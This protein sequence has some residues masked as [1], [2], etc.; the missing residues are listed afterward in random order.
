MRLSDEWFTVL[1]S[2]DEGRIVY[3]NG[4]LS[5]EEFRKSRKLS[6]RIELR[7]PY[8][9]GS[10]GM[11]TEETAE[12]ILQIEERIRPK[13]EKDKLAILT[14]N[15]IGGGV[16][17]WVFYCRTERVFEERLNEALADLPLLPLEIDVD[18]DADWEEYLDML[19]MN[20]GG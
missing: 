5:L 1:S 16:K 11:P 19:S 18:L 2:D 9:M 15:H 20:T 13:M 10:D 4:R 17:Y 3:V 8:E 14:G 7:L 12:L 6:V